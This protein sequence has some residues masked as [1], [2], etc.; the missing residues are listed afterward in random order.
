[1]GD[2]LYPVWSD[3]DN[4]AP[5]PPARICMRVETDYGIL[6]EFCVQLE[7]NSASR[8]VHHPPDWMQVARFDHNISSQRGHDIRQEGLHMDVYGNDGKQR[9]RHDFPDIPLPK[10]PKW[11]RGFLEARKDTLLS[12]FESEIGVP[13]RMRVYDS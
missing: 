4:A 1:M 11:C 3:W 10:A 13:V 8:L 12:R 5:E 6:S 2:T 7:Y 9:V